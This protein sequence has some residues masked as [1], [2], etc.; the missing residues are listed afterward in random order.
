MATTVPVIRYTCMEK[1]DAWFAGRVQGAIE[2]LLEDHVEK[3]FLYDVVH[4]HHKDLTKKITDVV[5]AALKETPKPV[6]TIK[7]DEV[8]L[9]VKRG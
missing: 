9:T 8:V 3:H 7:L 1:M 6:P 2:R 4:T 5:K